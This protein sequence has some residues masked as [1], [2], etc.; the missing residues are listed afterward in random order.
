MTEWY[1]MILSFKT[2]QAAQS[3]VS[4]NHIQAGN[5]GGIAAKQRSCPDIVQAMLTMNS[6]AYGIFPD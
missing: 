3:S 1:P 6:V 2:K 5:C 4:H